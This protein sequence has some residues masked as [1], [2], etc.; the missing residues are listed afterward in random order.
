LILSFRR[1]RILPRIVPP[2]GVA[3]RQTHALYLG[4]I[5]FAL[6]SCSI[7]SAQLATQE[8]SSPGSK[9]SSSVFKADG[10]IRHKP[11]AGNPW[12]Q[13]ATLTPSDPNNLSQF[14]D[15]VSIDGDTVVV[16]TSD[17]DNKFYASEAYVFVK[18][19]SGWANMTQVAILTASDKPEYFASS[20]AVSGDTIAIGAPKANTVYVYVKP[21]SGWKN[22]TETAK[23][24]MKGSDSGLGM[25]VSIAGDTIVAGAPGA[26]MEGRGATYVYV[27]PASGWKSMTQTA[28]LTSSDGVDGDNFG[29]AVSLNGDTVAAG[30]PQYPKGDGKAYVFVKPADGWVN[31][32]QTAEL[33]PTDGA[34][35]LGFGASV[36]IANDTVAVGE[37]YGGSEMAEA[38]VFVK[39]QSGWANMT[40]TAK[41]TA[42]VQAA[43]FGLSV[44]TTGNLVAVGDYYYG[45]SNFGN[46]GATFIYAKPKGGWKDT[47]HFEANLTGSD[48]RFNS[49]LGWSVAAQGNTVVAG[50]PGLMSGTKYSGG[51]FI[52]SVPE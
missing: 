51:A 21:A 32:T 48:A 8:S 24:T 7:S 41:L 28:R 19:K 11:V 22:M 31:M 42:S 12:V 16:G 2:E 17:P 40:Q 9:T 3:M 33:T 14:G 23:L 15:C 46:E 18:P 44:A 30:A 52:F 36:A 5:A 20:I 50:S 39:P 6:I 45:S 49:D 1:R 37:P 4:T 38:Y 43:W 25:S 27:K 29:W 10:A 13:L 35:Q 47:S 34:S 26:S